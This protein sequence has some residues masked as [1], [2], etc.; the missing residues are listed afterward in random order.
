MR[1]LLLLTLL[2]FLLPDAVAL[3]QEPAAPAPASR[4]TLPYNRTIVLPEPNPSEIQE[5]NNEGNICRAGNEKDY[6]DCKCVS[7]NY[8]QQRMQSK[9]LSKNFDIY[10]AKN[11]A[12]KA[13]PNTT[14]IAGRSY[15][16]CMSWAPRR[17]PDYQSFCECYGNAYA[18]AFAAKPAVT[19]QEGKAVMTTALEKCD[20]GGPIKDRIT[21]NARIRE[22]E[23]QGI[24][25]E[26]YPGS[27]DPNDPRKNRPPAP[28]P[29][30]LAPWQK[31]Q[32]TLFGK[33]TTRDTPQ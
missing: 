2:C 22:M 3:A 12:R 25:D 5:A 16:S 8:L 18:D 21:R 7:L 24:Y 1:I 20:S 17:R 15:T 14:A 10:T 27:V 31:M 6:F 30:P 23:Q 32:G 9:A 11:N 19:L 28:T 29:A 33:D 26:M 4:G 13:C